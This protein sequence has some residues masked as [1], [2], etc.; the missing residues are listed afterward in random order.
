[1]GFSRL[2]L[3]LHRLV[4]QSI[5]FFQSLRRRLSLRDEAHRAT[6]PRPLFMAFSAAR[7]APALSA[8]WAELAFFLAGSAALPAGLSNA[9]L[10]IALSSPAR[11]GLARRASLQASALSDR[12]QR[13]QRSYA[14]QCDGDD[15][16]RAL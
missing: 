16:C 10:C 15:D 7:L 1:M 13:L 9:N 6:L 5:R 14:R 4:E 12:G 2:S 11:R 8:R 3:K